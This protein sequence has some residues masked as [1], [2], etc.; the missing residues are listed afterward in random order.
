MGG[1]GVFA[2]FKTG[3][4]AASDCE[5]CCCTGAGCT[6]RCMIAAVRR[7]GVSG[8]EWLGRTCREEVRALQRPTAKTGNVGN[9]G[10]SRK[11]RSCHRGEVFIELGF[12]ACGACDAVACFYFLG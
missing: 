7:W 5:F 4:G 2:D 8:Y 9:R 1:G 6:C 11:G 3:V 12:V 10:G